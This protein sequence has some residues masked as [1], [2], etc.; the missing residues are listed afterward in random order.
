MPQLHSGVGSGL[1]DSGDSPD[2]LATP[3]DGSEEE[4]DA[5]VSTNDVVYVTVCYC[6]FA[7]GHTAGNETYCNAFLFAAWNVA[8]HMCKHQRL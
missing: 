2:L 7:A 3:Y 8:T 6:C 4:G 1:H 5:L